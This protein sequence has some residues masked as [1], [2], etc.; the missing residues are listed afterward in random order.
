MISANRNLKLA[1]YYLPL[2]IFSVIE[3]GDAFK[4]MRNFLRKLRKKI[5]HNL[6]LY[7][8]NLDSECY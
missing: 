4:E 3:I 7:W 2:I 1:C 5:H 6:E 8:E